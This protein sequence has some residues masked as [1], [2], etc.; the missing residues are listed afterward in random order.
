M[1]IKICCTEEDG[2][3][4]HKIR[5]CSMEYK[6]K[7]NQIHHVPQLECV[8]FNEKIIFYCPFCGKKIELEAEE[9]VFSRFI[10]S[11][12]PSC[13]K[14]NQKMHGEEFYNIETPTGKRMVCKYVCLNDHSEFHKL[15]DNTII[16][17]DGQLYKIDAEPPKKIEKLELFDWYTYYD[18]KG[19]QSNYENYLKDNFEL[20]LNEIID[21]LNGDR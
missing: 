7:D 10:D 5:T 2:E 9:D 12:A 4:N 19:T 14:C 3:K 8:I 21:R 6:V 17:E 16:Q 1:K 20:K 15:F 18:K 13:E 11:Q